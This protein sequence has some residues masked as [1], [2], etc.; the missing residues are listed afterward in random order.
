MIFRRST[1]GD[2]R[3]FFDLHDGMVSDNEWKLIKDM[4][5]VTVGMKGVLRTMNPEKVGLCTRIRGCIRK[6]SFRHDH[7]YRC[8]LGNR[9]QR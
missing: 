8:A 3:I 1:F 5:K 4:G 7:H 6:S 2:V 9:F